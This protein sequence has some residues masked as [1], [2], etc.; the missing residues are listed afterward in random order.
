MSAAI[1]GAVVGG[2][3]VVAG[4]YTSEKNRKAANKANSQAAALNERQAG[5][6]TM[7]GFWEFQRSEEQWQIYKDK[8]LPMELEAQELGVDARKLAV[9]RGEY[10]QDLYEN[11]YG[12]LSASFADDAMEGIEGQPERAARDARIA[13]DKA[14]DAEEGMRQRD[15]Q[16][17]GVRAS[18]GN[19]ESGSAD[20]G[21]ARA[22]AKAYSVNRAVE[23]ERDRVEDVNFNRKAAAL[24]RQPV[25]SAASQGGYS[26]VGPGSAHAGMNAASAA[27]GRASYPTNAIQQQGAAYAGA[28]GS[29]M[30]SAVQSGM[31]MLDSLQAIPQSSAPPI[32]MNAGNH[33]SA[34]A[35]QFGNAAP[36]QS[37]F[38]Y[39]LDFNEGG[40]VP[41]PFDKYAAPAAPAQL[42]HN[43]GGE[44]NGPAGVDQV[45]AYIESEAGER[46]PARLS[47]DEYVIPADV[48]KA[49]GT[50]EFDGIITKARESMES[51]KP[52]HELQ[53]QGGAR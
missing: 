27:I 16:R 45:P 11:Y 6:Q 4:L 21:L 48:V 15:L 17:R 9:E 3:G 20:I 35:I 44:V 19:F 50:A 25:N 31:Y 46:Y 37:S 38:N 40:R 8:V 41:S 49:V 2:V 10:D 51:A 52:L 24:G 12:P 42:E 29:G 26:S 47:R 30:S 43:P 39:S 33:T 32:N 28:A 18:S 7:I 13:V 34:P 1:A 5:I 23:A 22:A 36:P 53:R 14:F